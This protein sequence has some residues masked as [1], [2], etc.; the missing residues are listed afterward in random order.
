[1]K[2]A[3]IV[4]LRRLE[5]TGHKPPG[6]TDAAIAHATERD[7]DW[8]SWDGDALGRLRTALDPSLADRI[9]AGSRMARRAARAARSIAK[10]AIGIDR[11][12]DDDFDARLGVCAACPGGH[13]RYRKGKLHTCGPMLD[14]LKAEGKGTCGCILSKKARDAAENCPFGYWPTIAQTDT[15][16]ND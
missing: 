8:L 7:G 13:A 12:S 4:T 15:P 2:R 14:S 10:T 16:A 5:A 11:T 9:R 1:M 3:S 6:Y